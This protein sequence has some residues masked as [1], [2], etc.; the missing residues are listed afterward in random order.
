MNI[1][2]GIA[3]LLVAGIAIVGVTG[4]AD[5]ATRHRSKHRHSSVAG[6]IGGIGLHADKLNLVRSGG[7]DWLAPYLA[8]NGLPVSTF[9]AISARESGCARNGVHVANRTDLSTSRF[10]LN[11]RGSMPRYWSQLCGVSNWT[12]PG[13]SVSADVKCAAAAYHHMG[14][15]PWR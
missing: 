12:V 3:G 5:A 13:A 11:F 15:R 14:L 1:R 4:T 9:E 8:A 7:C 10:G 6:Y 2:Q